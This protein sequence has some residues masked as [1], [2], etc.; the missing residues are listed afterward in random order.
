MPLKRPFDAVIWWE[1]R[2]AL[3]NLALLPAGLAAVI[4]IELVGDHIFPSGEDAIE[5]MGLVFFGLVYAVAANLAYTVG[6]ISELLWSGGD[7]AIT[8]QRR[9]RVFRVGLI[10]SIVLTLLPGAVVPGLWILLRIH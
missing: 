3:F 1:K 8:E 9:S 6:W 5:P 4:V 2:R 7:T 10:F